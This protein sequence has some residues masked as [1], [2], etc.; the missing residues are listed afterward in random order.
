MSLACYRKRVINLNLVRCKSKQLTLKETESARVYS[1]WARLDSESHFIKAA[2]FASHPLIL[3]VVLTTHNL[4]KQVTNLNNILTT[5]TKLIYN[6]DY[7]FQNL[8]ILFK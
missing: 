6:F 4:D 8:M 5:L 3:L 1:A 2:L 7:Y